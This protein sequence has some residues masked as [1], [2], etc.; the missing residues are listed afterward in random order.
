M[1]FLNRLV[2]LLLLALSVN[3]AA[4]SVNGTLKKHQ[5]MSLFLNATVSIKNSKQGVISNLKGEFTLYL[6]PGDYVLV[7]RVLG[8]ETSEQ[9]IQVRQSALKV[10]IILA[11]ASQEIG[12]VVVTKDKSDLAKQLIRK[13]ASTEKK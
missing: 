12:E 13:S 5:K 7:T 10:T 2:L 3:A 11:D 9:N 4:T 6:S 8:Y 1:N